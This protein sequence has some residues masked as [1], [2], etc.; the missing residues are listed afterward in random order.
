MSNFSGMLLVDT[1]EYDVKHELHARNYLAQYYAKGVGITGYITLPERSEGA[2]DESARDVIREELRRASMSSADKFNWLVLDAGQQLE[3]MKSPQIEVNVKPVLDSAQQSIA[4]VMGVPIGIL[5]GNTD[6]IEDLEIFF[7]N[8]TI[9]PLLKRIE[10][11]INKRFVQNV[12]SG[13]EYQVRFDYRGVAVLK[14]EFMEV[15]RI[16]VALQNTG[17]ITPNEGRTEFLN[18]PEFGDII[19]DENDWGNSIEPLVMAKLAA[20]QKAA[21]GGGT[22]ILNGSGPSMSMTGSG[23]GRDQ[24]ANGEAQMIDTGGSK[25][26]DLEAV[27]NYVNRNTL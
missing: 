9:K 8:K 20:V 6:K 4:M 23:G 12:N 24:S 21:G 5:T 18:F 17:S 16:V 3:V 7:W 15:A 11:Y 14:K 10:E 13:D 25:S 2:V 27:W 26:F 1:V 22:A 19:L